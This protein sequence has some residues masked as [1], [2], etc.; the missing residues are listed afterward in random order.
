MLL[1]V[2]V[3]Y[4]KPTMSFLS[5]LRP[6]RIDLFNLKPKKT[7]LEYICQYHVGL[8]FFILGKPIFNE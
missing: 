1:V 2:S 4:L 8:I 3:E 5:C 7:S 6:S